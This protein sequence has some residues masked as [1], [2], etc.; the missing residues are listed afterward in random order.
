MGIRLSLLSVLFLTTINS[1]I[2]G[3][4]QIVGRFKSIGKDTIISV[5]KPIGGFYN[6]S[7]ELK[8]GI[9]IKNGTFSTSLTIDEPGFICL[10]SK[11]IPK[12]IFYVE[13]EGQVEILFFKDETGRSKVKY[14]GSNE[15]A[16][17]ILANNSPLDNQNFLQFGLPEIFKTESAD[18]FFEIANR[19]LEISTKPFKVQLEKKRITQR[20]YQTMMAETEQAMLYWVSMYLKD[21]QM[22]DNELPYVTKLNH[23]EV[24][25]LAQIFYSKY[26]PYQSRYASATR[27]QQNQMIKSKLIEKNLLD[28]E[29]EMTPIWAKFADDFIKIVSGLSAI[30]FAP[31]S[32]QMSFVGNILLSALT[33]QSVDNKIFNQA[34]SIYKT[35]FPS[36]PFN[37][38]VVSHPY[39]NKQQT[40]V[41]ENEESGEVHLTK[42]IDAGEIEN[43]QNLIKTNFGGKTV[44]V[45]FWATWCSP[46]IAEFRNEPSLKS[47]L[48]EKKIVILYVSIDNPSDKVKWE[49]AIAKYKLSG[50]HCL[51]NKGIKEKLDKWFAGIPRYMLFDSKGELLDDNLPKP[52]TTTE[53]YTRIT[54]LL[55]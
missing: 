14:S 28:N 50:Y 54:Q 17:N 13:N 29:K 7:F 20:C 37:P 11:S 5:Y 46:C 39:F 3:Q 2:C 19:E 23:D 35:K 1:T 47:F 4:V 42:F 26:D 6:K 21:F 51:V 43:L 36:S 48:Q 49:K 12:T 8:D 52:S 53:L 55:R 9:K 45:D 41:Q 34:F 10:Q 40:H 31:D 38:L 44:F 30:D 22:P 24:K 16:N 18:A 27:T 15:I 32:V 33:Y 25:K